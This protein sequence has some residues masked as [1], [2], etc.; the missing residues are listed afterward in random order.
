MLN[1]NSRNSSDLAVPETGTST[2]QPSSTPTI[3]EP[4][5]GPRPKPRNLKPPTQ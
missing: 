2:N 4:V 3:S 5:T 1:R